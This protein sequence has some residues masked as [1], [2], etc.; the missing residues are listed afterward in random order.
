MLAAFDHL[1]RFRGRMGAN[2]AGSQFGSSDD[3]ACDPLVIRDVVPYNQYGYH[4]MLP[5]NEGSITCV[6][7]TTMR[8]PFKEIERAILFIGT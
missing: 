2:N 1:K 5:C 6:H 3:T 4:I 7:Y 8:L